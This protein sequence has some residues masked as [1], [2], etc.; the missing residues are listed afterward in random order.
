MTVKNT[1][2]KEFIFTDR[3]RLALECLKIHTSLWDLSEDEFHTAE[4][5]ETVSGAT[6][7]AEAAYLLADMLIAQSKLTPTK[8]VS[9][10]LRSVNPKDLGE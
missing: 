8:P 5:V 6:Y 10:R 4:Q 9:S 3:D 7:A 2:P 1:D